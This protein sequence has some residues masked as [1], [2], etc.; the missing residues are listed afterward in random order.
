MAGTDEVIRPTQTSMLA[1]KGIRGQFQEMST[2]RIQMINQAMRT[3]AHTTEM[4]LMTTRAQRPI[5]RE[6]GTLSF[7]MTGIGRAQITRSSRALHALL[8]PSKARMS[9]QWGFWSVLM[10]FQNSSIGLH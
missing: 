5:L 10:D 2:D 6:K 1:R 3:R 8:K 4:K 9:K 7:Q